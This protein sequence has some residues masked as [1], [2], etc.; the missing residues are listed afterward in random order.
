MTKKNIEPEPFTREE[1]RYINY[2][3]KKYGK[4]LSTKEENYRVYK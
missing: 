2:L 3:V 4:K 1:E